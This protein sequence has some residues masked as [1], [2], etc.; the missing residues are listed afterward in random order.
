MCD[1][2]VDTYLITCYYIY[3]LI[4]Q[5]EKTN[6]TKEVTEMFTNNFKQWQTTTTQTIN[7]SD[8]TFNQ[9]NRTVANI[10]VT[11]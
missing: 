5:V 9:S 6:K 10:D 4:K 2:I 11:I 1:K 8:S 7:F 3:K